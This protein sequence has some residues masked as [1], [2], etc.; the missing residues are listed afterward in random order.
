MIT[1]KILSQGTYDPI[2]QQRV[3]DFVFPI[4]AKQIFPVYIGLLIV[5][6]RH[7]TLH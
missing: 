2:S 5:R 1:R 6:Y 4:H 7:Y 3:G